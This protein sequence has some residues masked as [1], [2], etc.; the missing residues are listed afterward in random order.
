MNFFFK[1]D[2]KLHRGNA[3]TKKILEEILFY[4]VVEVFNGVAKIYI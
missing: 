2:N 3:L 4:I 1:R